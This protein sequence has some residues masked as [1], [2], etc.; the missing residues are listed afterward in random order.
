MFN[1]SLPLDKRPCPLMEGEPHVLVIASTFI[2]WSLIGAMTV[3]KCEICFMYVAAPF[4][5]VV[6]M[7]QFG[8]GMQW[9]LLEAI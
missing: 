6:K 7:G 4:S 2:K 1:Q 3:D 5:A 9:K 8:A